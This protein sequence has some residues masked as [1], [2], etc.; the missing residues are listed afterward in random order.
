MLPMLAMLAVGYL[1]KRHGQARVAKEQAN[2][3]AGHVPAAPVEEPASGGFGGL[4]GILGGLLG[5]KGGVLASIFDKNGDGNP[6][7]D[8]LR[9]AGMGGRT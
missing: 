2:T 9:K 7:D 6:L 5:G 8:I 1:A 4:G 3:Q